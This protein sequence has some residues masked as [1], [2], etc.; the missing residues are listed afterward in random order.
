MGTF[1]GQG[2]AISNLNSNAGA[3]MHAGLFGV[4]HEAVIQNVVLENVAITVSADNDRLRAGTLVSW[5]NN[6]QIRNCS[7]S[8]SLD[9]ATDILIGGLIG[10]CTDGSQVVG[11]SSAVHVTSSFT[12]DEGP[13]GATVG[14]VVGQWEN[15]GKTSAAIRSCSFSGSL[16][17]ADPTSMNGGILGANFGREGMDPV[18]ISN[19]LVTTTDFTQ[20]AF[21]SYMGG[22]TS[23]STIEGC[24]WPACYL[25]EGAD[26]ESGPFIFPYGV[27]YIDDSQIGFGAHDTFPTEPAGDYY[28]E[29]GKDT[30]D[31]SD[32]SI[33]D[34]LNSG[35]AEESP[36]WTLGT[37]G[38]PVLSWQSDR[39][40]A[41]YATVDA[42]LAE[43]AT[44]E[45]AL[46]TAESLAALDDALAAVERNLPST[47]QETVNAMAQAIE[48]ALDAL[49][50]LADYTAVDAAL[51][52]VPEDLSPYTQDSAAKLQSAVDA[53]VR[54]YGESRQTEVDAMA[55]NIEEAV[56]AL[57]FI[58]VVVPNPT[59]EVAVQQP[60][61]GTISVTPS[62]AEKG[63]TVTVTVLPDEGFEVKDVAVEDSAG[64]TVEVVRNEDGTWSFTMPAGKATVSAL[65]A[66]DGDSAC[67]SH[68]F[69][70]VDQKLWYHLAVDWAVTSGAMGGYAGT[71][72]FG[73]DDSL[74]RA[75]MA[76][77][78]Y[79]LAG[80]PDAST[81]EAFGDV[82]E[83]DWFAAPVSWAVETGLFMG[84]DNSGMFGPNDPLTREQAAA[85]LMRWA[86]IEGGD[87]SNRA[88]LT[89]Y[90]DAGDVS[91]WAAESL[92]W[93]VAEGIVN[94][95]ELADGTRILQP[96]SACTR[97]QLAALL[98]GWLS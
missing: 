68:R 8:G 4:A 92:S 85:V 13:E 30:Q 31:F 69:A 2:H 95:V 63:Q 89:A 94:G 51:A 78:A 16:D 52:K 39:I 1:D 77:V 79:N 17:I 29:V 40:P 75:Q 97:A 14:G 88:D 60:E 53:V 24:V 41:D 36:T 50:R 11:C 27:L 33:L 91:S 22:L 15:S 38:T 81:T 35:V 80:K 72:L 34:Y 6:S 25:Q 61:N 44:V 76:A 54:G 67:P 56:A 49:E 47:E 73:P 86:R 70:D 9:C 48:N 3:D 55:Q 32:P 43:A 37:D 64:E 65:I 18:E 42:A 7:A 20:P 5:A 19:C 12:D 90:P 57:A 71:S 28:G 96:Q 46:Y 84:Y 62:R 23:N 83:G 59:Y 26:V 58:P 45:R 66:C 10:Q 82:H 87:T 74:T 21:A 93:A 98:C